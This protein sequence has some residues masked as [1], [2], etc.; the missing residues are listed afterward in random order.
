M[1]QDAALEL[2]R[3]AA[4]GA[5]LDAAAWVCYACGRH[6]ALPPVLEAATGLRTAPHCVTCGVRVARA[7]PPAVLAEVGL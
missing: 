4:S 1:A 7:V 5:P 3:C 2:P 6:Y